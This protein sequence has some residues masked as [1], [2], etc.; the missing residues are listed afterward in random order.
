LYWLPWVWGNGGQLWDSQ[1][2]LDLHTAKAINALT[3]AMHWTADGLSPKRKDSARTTMTQLFLQQRLAF[4][5]TGRWTV[6]LL[7]E[8]AR[9]HWGVWPL[10]S[11]TADSITGVDATGYAI[12]KRTRYPKEARDLVDF[13]TSESVLR[14]QAQS[15][16]MVA[17][18]SLVANQT[19]ANEPLF[20]SVVQQSLTTGQPTPSHP[21]WP[22]AEAAIAQAIEP[23][24]DTNVTPKQLSKALQPL[25][26]RFCLPPQGKEQ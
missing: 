1:G 16:L 18:R 21:R 19:L 11:G 9:F 4:L 24:W 12:A 22:E 13:L 3:R 8:Q 7:R 23:Y 14:S 6:P 5:V 2:C 20:L 15:G 10:P 25:S 17:A 26:T